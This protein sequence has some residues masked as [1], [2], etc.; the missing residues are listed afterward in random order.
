MFAKILKQFVKSIDIAFPNCQRRLWE[1]A[2]YKKCS[3]VSQQACHVNN[4]F[5]WGSDLSSDPE[6]FEAFRCTAKR[7][8]GPVGERS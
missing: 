7:F 2:A 1:C 5:V 6:L 8:L 4:E 3:R